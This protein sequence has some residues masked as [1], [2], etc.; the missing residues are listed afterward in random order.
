MYNFKLLPRRYFTAGVAVALS[1]VL[2]I[3]ASTPTSG[4]T[5]DVTR[6]S[7]TTRIS[8][9]PAFDAPAGGKGGISNPV[10]WCSDYS[11]PKTTWT[12]T[13]LESGWT[14][15]WS[16]RGSYPGYYFPRVPAGEYRSETLGTCRGVDNARSQRLTVAEKT[17]DGTV[18]RAEWRRIHR[19]MTRGEV[20]EIVGSDG[21]DPNRYAGKLT[22]TY[23]LMAFWRWS[24][25]EYRGGRV[26]AKYWN[27]GHD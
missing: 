5:G 4:S 3:A 25:V 13:N 8:P 24:V 27:V 2:S 1:G 14:E 23:D 16:W 18:S 10:V 26:T 20:A 22:L 9:A 6:S 19:G 11:D 15:T 21:R 7:V 12:L 17:V